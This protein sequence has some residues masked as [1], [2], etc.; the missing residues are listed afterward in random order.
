MGYDIIEL[1]VDEIG[2]VQRFNVEYIPFYNTIKDDYK[3]ARQ[4]VIK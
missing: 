3:K 2:N 1:Y 4:L